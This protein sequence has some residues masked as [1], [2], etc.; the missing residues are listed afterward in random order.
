MTFCP[1]Q[2]RDFFVKQRWSLLPVIRLCGSLFTTEQWSQNSLWSP[3]LF[4]LLENHCNSGS[5][6][7]SSIGTFPYKVHFLRFTEVTFFRSADRP[8]RSLS[9]RSLLPL[10]SVTRT[11]PEVSFN[12]SVVTEFPW[13][14]RYVVKIHMSSQDCLHRSMFVVEKSPLEGR[15][16]TSRVR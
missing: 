9:H 15:G 16:L 1:F 4:G 5:G 13:S 6:F 10:L 14:K 2:G 8:N 11:G 7:L 12:S 3:Y